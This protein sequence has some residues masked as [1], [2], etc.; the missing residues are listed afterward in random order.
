VENNID[1][2]KGFLRDL[3]ES[4]VRQLA[5]NKKG[6]KRLL[7]PLGLWIWKTKILLSPARPAMSDLMFALKNL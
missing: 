5:L 7:L 4:L 1:S 2:A 6:G 3:R